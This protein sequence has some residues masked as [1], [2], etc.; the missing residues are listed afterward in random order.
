MLAFKNKE[1]ETIFK[2]FNYLKELLEYE[3]SH[4]LFP[5]ILTDNDVKFPKPDVIE[6]NG[7]HAYKT[8]LFYCDLGLL[9]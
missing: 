9:V 4:M 1:A 7:H 3:Q 6:F 8:K 5:I 2:V